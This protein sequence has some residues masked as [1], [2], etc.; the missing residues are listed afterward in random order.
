MIESL[1]G[2][3]ENIHYTNFKFVSQYWITVPIMALINN[4]LIITLQVTTLLGCF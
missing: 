2:L 1:T 4:Y 3:N